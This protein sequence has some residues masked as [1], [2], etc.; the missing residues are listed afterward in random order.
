M[1]REKVRSELGASLQQLGAVVSLLLGLWGCG[2]PVPSAAMNSVM[3]SPN[4][5][6]CLKHTCL[7]SFYVLSKGWILYGGI[8]RMKENFL[9]SL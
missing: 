4:K 1:K 2:D 5:K 6:S 8:D 7:L 3:P 9:K